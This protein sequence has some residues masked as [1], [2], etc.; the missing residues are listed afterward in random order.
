VP[1]LLSPKCPRACALQEESHHDEKP[2]H[3]NWR[4]D[5]LSAT[6]EIQCPAT[7]T[8]HSQKEVKKYNDF[9]LK[10]FV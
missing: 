4:V 7:K 2:A 3:H 1:Q 5:L 10:S 6:R 8:Q 9:F